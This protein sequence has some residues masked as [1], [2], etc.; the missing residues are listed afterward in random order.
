M[1]SSK[2]S[3]KRGDKSS[4]ERVSPFELYYQLTFMSAIASAGVARSKIFDLSTQTMPRVRQYF[5]AINRLVAEFRFDYPEACRRVG[6]SAPSE[7]M[8]SF[9]LRLSDALRSGEP[10][11]DYLTREA[12]VQGGDYH[13]AYERSLEVL[14]QWTNA[15]SSIVISVALVIIV[16]II[17]AMIYSSDVRTM[18]GMVMTG[19]V[20]SGLS[21]WI[22]FRSA[23]REFMIVSPT[24]GSAEQKRVYRWSRIALPAAGVALVLTTLIHVPV[25]VQ[26]ILVAAI[27]MPIGLMA[28]KSDGQTLKKD[29]EFSTFLRSTGGMAT[30]SGATLRESLGRI[31]LTSFPML[32]DDITR[33]ST[34]LQALIDPEVCWRQFGMETG[35]R[36][37]SDVVD[38]FYN[39]VKMGGDPERVGYLCS[40]FAAKTVQLR[41][42]RR[43][44]TGTFTGLTTVMHI[45]VA[46]LMVFV[47]SIVQS[48]AQ[49]VATLMPSQ[50]AMGSGPRF[51]MSMA[52]FTPADLEF[53]SGVTVLM[54]V[55]LALVSAIAIVVTDGG[56]RLK[57]TLYLGMM[58][59]IS[60]LAFIVVPPLVA[61]ILVK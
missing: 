17:S 48:F 10:I 14:K 47:L 37:I 56:G 39:A 46:A 6:A 18:G 25:G 49:L 19:M 7:N 30:A 42:K 61:G 60:G 53:L 44:I 24:K 41:S 12:E 13:N 9:L 5:A 27:I 45:V 1:T 50:D 2:S 31:D 8:R 40:L 23:P 55:V 26:M 29:V 4:F 43:L 21:A 28:A 15:F 11:S 59:V 22:I 51:T 58:L 54:V 57:V 3:A 32:K 16:Q 34:R 36:L 35:S 20:M 52:Q 38:V 33:L